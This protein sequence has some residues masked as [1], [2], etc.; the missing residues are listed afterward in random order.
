MT[1]RAVFAVL[2][3]LST[4]G[5]L[6]L[7]YAAFGSSNSGFTP[8]AALIG[9]FVLLVFPAIT[10][11]AWAWDR[12]VRKRTAARLS[13]RPGPVLVEHA[14]GRQVRGAPVEPAGSACEIEQDV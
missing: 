13:R 9:I 7:A 11:W 14:G 2:A 10:V 1:R 3:V 8:T 5:S 4:V 12:S 6:A